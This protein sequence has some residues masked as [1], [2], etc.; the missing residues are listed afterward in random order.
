MLMPSVRQNKVAMQVRRL[1]SNFIMRGDVADPRVTGL[2]TI[3]KV[4]VS[5]DLRDAWVYVSVLN[6]HGTPE[7]VMQGLKSVQRH[8]QR[9]VADGLGL[10]SAPRMEFRLD[11]SLKREAAVL[12]Q[13]DEAMQATAAQPHDPAPK[14]ERENSKQKGLKRSPKERRKPR[15]GIEEVMD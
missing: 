14:K 1:V 10:R 8:M 7:T 2:V 13:I 3:T 15:L 6:Q 9:E 5:P 12:R 4:E 11:D